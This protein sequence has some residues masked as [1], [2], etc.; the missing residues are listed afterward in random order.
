M[1]KRLNQSEFAEAIN[2]FLAEEL[3]EMYRPRMAL[4]QSLISDLERA[5][6]DISFLAL[7]GMSRLFR[8]PESDLLNG[9]LK[10][11]RANGFHSSAAELDEAAICFSTQFP[12]QSFLALS[13][14]EKSSA[15]TPIVKHKI[16]FYELKGFLDFL[17]SPV[18]SLSRVQK[19]TVLKAMHRYFTKGIDRRLFFLVGNMISL[20]G[21]KMFY[22]SQKSQTIYFPTLVQNGRM[23]VSLVLES[24]SG[25]LLSSSI[26]SKF[27]EE[28]EIVHSSV[29][30]LEIAIEVL[31]SSQNVG[32]IETLRAFLNQCDAHKTVPVQV[33]SL[34]SPEIQSVL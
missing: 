28:G 24:A 26:E 9:N 14:L 5:R 30:L 7:Y 20:T 1:S 27:I 32:L 34:L 3:P 18:S 29:V 2:R 13:D 19:I 4:T 17:F 6:T 15:K 23:P 8:V 10:I 12:S 25:R 22:L 11:A 16:Y 21:L 31:T 33:K